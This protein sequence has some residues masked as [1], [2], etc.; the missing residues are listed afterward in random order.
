MT[1]HTSNNVTYTLLSRSGNVF[2]WSA[3]FWQITSKFESFVTVQFTEVALNMLLFLTSDMCVHGLKLKGS[4]IWY[5]G[6]LKQQKD[7]LFS[8]YTAMS[9]KL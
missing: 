8:D 2:L 4:V 7:K 1:V 3:L 9:Y 5:P 6:W